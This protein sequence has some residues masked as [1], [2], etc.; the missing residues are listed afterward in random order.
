MGLENHGAASFAD[1]DNDTIQNY[2]NLELEGN[3][4]IDK[5]QMLT[6]ASNLLILH[7]IF[8]PRTN[9]TPA[10]SSLDPAP[11]SNLSVKNESP[12]NQRPAFMIWQ[13]FIELLRNLVQ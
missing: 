9:K 12:Q 7:F 4:I 5:E 1:Q 10:F 3:M 6:D 13:R 11:K 2:D 8:F